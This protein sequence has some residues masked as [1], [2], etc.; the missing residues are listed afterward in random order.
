MDNNGSLVLG[1][2]YDLITRTDLSCK[3]KKRYPKFFI[4]RPFREYFHLNFPLLNWMICILLSEKL[5]TI[6]YLCWLFIN[7]SYV[8]NLRGVLLFKFLLNFLLLVEVY[9]LGISWLETSMTI[10]PVSG[11][12]TSQ[13]FQREQ[14]CCTCDPFLPWCPGKEFSDLFGFQQHYLLCFGCVYLIHEQIVNTSFW[15]QR[16]R[17]CCGHDGNHSY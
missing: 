14:Q 16:V 10:R 6:S 2:R 12:D 15:S 1:P 5:T 8:R 3:V 13:A 11:I 9:L 17:S 4:F 7:K